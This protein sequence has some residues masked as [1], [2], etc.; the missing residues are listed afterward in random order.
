VA[1]QMGQ[2]PKVGEGFEVEGIRVQATRV[3]KRRVTQVRIVPP[4]PKEEAE[5][6]VGMNSIQ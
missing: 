2:I 3:W 1:E 4:A 5:P 6:L